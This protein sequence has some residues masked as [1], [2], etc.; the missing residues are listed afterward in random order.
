WQRVPGTAA[1][2]SGVSPRWPELVAASRALHAALAGVPVP[3]WRGTEENPWVIG[4]QVAWQERDPGALLGPAA[5]ELAGQVQRLLTALR[6]VA[7]PDQLV[8]ADL[9]GN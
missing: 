7:L 9:A 3:P 6:P 1:D 5:G 8:H 4:D 2:W